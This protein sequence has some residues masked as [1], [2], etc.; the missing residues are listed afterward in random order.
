MKL[1]VTGA[2][3]FLGRAVVAEALARGHEVRALARPATAASRLQ[4]R[5]HPLLSWSRQDLRRPHRLA[6]ELADRDAVIHLAAN[7]TA[8]FYQQM[9]GN[10][11]A[12]E[13]LLGAMTNAGIY[14]LVLVSSF[15]VYDYRQLPTGALLDETS[16]LETTP[17][18]RDAYAQTKLWQERV[19]R[20]WTD[21]IDGALTVL[22]PGVIFGRDNLWTGRL[23]MQL[24]SHWWLCIGR[25]ARLPLTHVHNCADAVV[26]AA[27]TPDAIGRTYNIVDDEQPSIRQY[28]RQ[29]K[30]RHEPEP[31]VLTIPWPLA[32]GMSRLL[33][34]LDRVFFQGRLRLPGLLIPEQ[35]H[36][37]CKPLRYTADRLKYELGWQPHYTL[38]EG[39]TRDGPLTRVLTTIPF[40][41]SLK[42]RA[43][44]KPCAAVSHI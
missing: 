26:R 29:I 25:N 44:R 6:E 11:V 43:T 30:A 1:L 33:A 10:V 35:L 40:H 22:R 19:T 14:R 12:T 36:A 28:V 37:R 2:T 24:G 23:G 13:N 41:G 21:D 39:I 32:A 38:K 20:R 34:G 3:G 18:Q 4:P 8:D 31:R 16:S 5:D 9:A 27:T 15:S 42:R 17:S 7:K